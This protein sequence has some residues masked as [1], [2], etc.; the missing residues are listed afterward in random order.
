MLLHPL[1]SIMLFPMS[2]AKISK[3][4]WVEMVGQGGD[5]ED[6][7]LDRDLV[8]IG[9]KRDIGIL[10]IGCGNAQDDDRN[11]RLD[12]SKGE[13]VEGELAHFLQSAKILVIGGFS[14]LQRRGGKRRQ[15]YPGRTWRG[16]RGL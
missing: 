14:L 13:Y 10:G 15:R 12:N 4:S 7:C 16:W 8:P 6:I 1:L 5:K 2:S 9:G 11:D 3:L